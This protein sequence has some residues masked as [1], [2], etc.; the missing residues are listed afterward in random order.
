MEYNSW[1][2]DHGPVVHS[3]I[4]AQC[5]KTDWRSIR[6]MEPQL[7]CLPYCTYVRGHETYRIRARMRLR[8]TYGE[9]R[10]PK[11]TTYKRRTLLVARLVCL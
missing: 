8:F 1:W 10:A 5:L 6:Q 11:P 4:S 3:Y 7:G 2:D 9:T